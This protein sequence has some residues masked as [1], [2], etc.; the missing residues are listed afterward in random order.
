M[1]KP[2]QTAYDRPRWALSDEEPP[3]CLRC[4][5]VLPWEAAIKGSKASKRC[6]YCKAPQEC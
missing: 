6:P 4:G 2:E 1:D 3:T 5:N